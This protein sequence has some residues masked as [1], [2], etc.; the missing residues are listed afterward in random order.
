MRVYARI[1]SGPQAADRLPRAA[2]RACLNPLST[3]PEVVP[4]I[5]TGIALRFQ[6]HIQHTFSKASEKRLRCMFGAEDHCNVG[7]KQHVTEH[8]R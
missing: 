3:L 2:A 7:R 8:A 6:R 1:L 4:G 5:R